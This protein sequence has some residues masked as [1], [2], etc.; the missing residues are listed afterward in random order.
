MYL[1]SGTGTTRCSVAE[2]QQLPSG[3]ALPAKELKMS[4]LEIRK[5]APKTFWYEFSPKLMVQDGQE[6]DEVQGPRKLWRPKNAL[7]HPK[8]NYKASSASSAGATSLGPRCQA[9]AQ[10]ISESEHCNFEC[11]Y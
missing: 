4:K 10:G 7:A 6:M 2:G 1:L 9:S 8:P 3:I 5:R 11:L